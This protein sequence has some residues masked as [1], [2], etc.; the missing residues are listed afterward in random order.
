MNVNDIRRMI[1]EV[2]KFK[3]PINENVNNIS[4]IKNYL[5]RYFKLGSIIDPASI[6]INNNNVRLYHQT[7][8]DNFENIKNEQKISISKSSGELNNEPIVIWGKIVKDKN[9]NGFYGSPKE[10][11]TIEYQ[12]PY[13]EV[14]KGTGGVSR[15][16]TSNEIIAYHDPRLFNVKEVVDNYLNEMLE[17][18]D[19]FMTF[20][21][22]WPTNIEYAYYL[23]SNA[24]KK[25]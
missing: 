18:L 11:F 4:S 19:F 7:D 8:L 3:A 22:S 24:I 1:D 2:N 5:Y 21:K 25:M 17:N 20:N 10:R 13:N 12:I 6:P 9:D 14:N 16:I 23:I 15:D